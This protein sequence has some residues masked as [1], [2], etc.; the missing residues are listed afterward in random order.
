MFAA[1]ENEPEIARALLSSN[2]LINTKNTA[3]HSALYL[4]KERK[5]SRMVS[6]LKKKGAA[7]L[8]FKIPKGE[9]KKTKK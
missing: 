2:A 3:G 5:Y 6:L 1:R 9:L 4:A 8:A 7:P